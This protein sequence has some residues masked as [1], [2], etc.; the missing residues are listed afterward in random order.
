MSKSKLKKASLQQ[1]RLEGADLREAELEKADL[2]ATYDEAT[3]WP[4]GFDPEKS[5]A[6]K[7]ESN[8][9]NDSKQ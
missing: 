5:G 6:V 1:T 4:D 2:R 3:K 7:V 8:S 9:A